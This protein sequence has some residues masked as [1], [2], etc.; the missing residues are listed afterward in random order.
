MSEQKDNN[1]SKTLIKELYNLSEAGVFDNIDADTAETSCNFLLTFLNPTIS[2]EQAEKLFGK[3]KELIKT[4]Y[5][6]KDK[7]LHHSIQI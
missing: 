7:S 2:Y 5:S 1:R 3:K 4:S 6:Q